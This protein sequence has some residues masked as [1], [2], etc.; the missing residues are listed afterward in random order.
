MDR[1][2]R[3]FDGI[4]VH[5][6][7]FNCAL[8]GCVACFY[9]INPFGIWVDSNS[10]EY[11]IV[12]NIRPELCTR[13]KSELYRGLYSSKHRILT[14]GDGD[15]SFSLAIARNIGKNCS[16]KLVCTS[17]ESYESVCNVY[18]T[19]HEILEELNSLKVNVYHEIDATNISIEGPN[20]LPFTSYDRIVWNFPCVRVNS[21]GFDGQTKELEENINLLRNFFIQASKI[22]TEN[23]EI[24]VTHKTF[25]PF[26]WWNIVEIAKECNFIHMGSIVFD[27]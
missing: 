14:L 24:H 23:G 8:N 22:I 16:K 3:N 10:V 11:P 9:K 6:D 5:I 1:K 21:K 4:Y 2:S 18:S 19:S 13:S 26:C 20:C 17:H 12:P 27:R 7:T 25:E 15:F